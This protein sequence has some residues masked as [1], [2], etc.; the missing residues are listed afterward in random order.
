MFCQQDSCGH[1]S[2]YEKQ[3]ALRKNDSTAFK[4]S[5][6]SGAILNRQRETARSTKE[7]QTS[8]TGLSATLQ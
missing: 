2:G 5:E 8:A 1:Q 3:E 6:H 7:Q 4:V